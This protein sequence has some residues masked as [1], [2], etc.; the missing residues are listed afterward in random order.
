MEVR[1]PLGNLEPIELVLFSFVLFKKKKNLYL[2][3]IEHRTGME[4]MLQM[5]NFQ[6]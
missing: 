5:V 2:T 6:G 4:P 1:T 3:Q